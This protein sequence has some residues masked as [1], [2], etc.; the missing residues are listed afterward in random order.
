MSDPYMDELGRW[1]AAERAGALDEADELFGAVAS[2]H[3]PLL[4]E[5]AGLTAAILAAVPRT[6]KSS[7]FAL[8]FGLAGTRWA[9]AT[10]AAAVGV[11]GVSFATVSLDQLLA[12]SSWSVEGLARLVHGA[13]AAFAAAFGVCSA[14]ATVLVD[15]GRA[16]MLV[17][18]SGAAP[19]MIVAN[20]LVAGLAFVGLS[21]LLSRREECY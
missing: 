6:R 2:R 3:L 4:P 5:P 12:L 15:L 11:L 17:A 13:S 14:A 10:V 16:A 21:R 7:R 19:A 18:G 9:R 1:L 20:V 8:V